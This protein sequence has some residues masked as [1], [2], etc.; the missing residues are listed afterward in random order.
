MRKAIIAMMVYAVI[1]GILTII[2]FLSWMRGSVLFSLGG[3]PKNWVNG[4]V[5][6]FSIVGLVKSLY[7]I[8][9]LEIK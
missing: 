8:I 9:M 3:F 5:F 7:H 4:L 1:F 2:S 6:V